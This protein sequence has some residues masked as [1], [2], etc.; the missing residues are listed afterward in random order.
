[1]TKH[2]PTPWWIDKEHPLSIMAADEN[3][4]EG[5]VAPWHVANLMPDCG[6]ND[7]GESD[8]NAAFIVRA[9]NNHA[10]LVAALRGLLG[11]IEAEE[12]GNA[13]CLRRAQ[14]EARA[15]LQLAKES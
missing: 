14:L 5:E 15:A 11:G 9:V 13:G 8:A 4:V 1:M 2:T 12:N 3:Y 6:G 7:D 10:A